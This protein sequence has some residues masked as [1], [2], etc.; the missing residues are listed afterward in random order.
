VVR[1]LL[2]LDPG[3]PRDAARRRAPGCAQF[4]RRFVA[5]YGNA[6]DFEARLG[7]APWRTRWDELRRVLQ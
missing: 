2:P 6:A 1:G 7:G 3:A 4:D 5:A